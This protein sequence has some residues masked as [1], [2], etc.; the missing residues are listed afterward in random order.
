MSTQSCI[1]EDSRD[2]DLNPDAWSVISLSV[3]ALLRKGQGWPFK[4]DPKKLV[5]V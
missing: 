2:F 4:I 5:N 3:V 1:T